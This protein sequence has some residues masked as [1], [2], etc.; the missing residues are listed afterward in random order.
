M[1]GGRGKP[2]TVAPQ[3]LSQVPVEIISQSALNAGHR[4]Q[5]DSVG[6]VAG[7]AHGCRRQKRLVVLSITPLFILF[8]F[9]GGGGGRGEEEE[10]EDEEKKTRT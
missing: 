5:P 8:P 10:E 3:L 9:F 2:S 4:R 7:T 1:E 6:P